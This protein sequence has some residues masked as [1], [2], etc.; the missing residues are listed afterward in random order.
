M[1][2]ASTRIQTRSKGM[3]T[4]IS[5]HLF[6]CAITAEY[7]FETYHITFPCREKIQKCLKFLLNF[8]WVIRIVS[9]DVYLITFTLYFSNRYPGLEKQISPWIY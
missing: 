2:I 9:K 6:E 1:E 5:Q 4:S 8:Q 3:F 7:M